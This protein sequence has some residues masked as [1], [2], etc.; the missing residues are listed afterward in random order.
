MNVIEN[1]GKI[2]AVA[3]ALLYILVFDESQTFQWVVFASVLLTIGIPHGALDHVL[4][5]GGNKTKKLS[6]F[7]LKYL[8]II[9][10][11]LILW[12]IVPEISLAI[13]LLISAYHFGQGHFIQ[14][15]INKFKKLTYFILGCNFLAIILFSDYMA[16]A[17]ILE[18]IIDIK[19]F[20]NYGSI[21]MFSL[22]VFS[23]ILVSI[24]NLNKIHLLLAEIIFLSLLLYILPVLL[25]FILYFGFWH[26]LPSMMAE[27]ESLTA[28]IQ[29]GKI[30]KFISQLAPF[31]IISFIGIGIIL[32]L[33]KSYLNEDQMILLFFIL[34]SLISAPH[35]WVMNNFLEKRV[36]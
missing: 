19:P 20:F 21:A 2:T 16:T 7:L 35:I 33:A 8:G 29:Q 24:Q 32:Y 18:S 26:A 31:S 5:E 28:R 27:F 9:A 15:K 12:I 1:I 6:L 25:A 11:Y 34:I 30:K 22:F 3:I 4:P 17:E 10:S 23:L 36:P 14:L 13:F